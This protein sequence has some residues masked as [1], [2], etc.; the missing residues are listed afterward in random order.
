MGQGAAFVLVG[1]S[2]GSRKVGGG[3]AIVKK[4]LALF[5]EHNFLD[6]TV[7]H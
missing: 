7:F 4:N 1:D 2:S 5:L 6:D 3:R